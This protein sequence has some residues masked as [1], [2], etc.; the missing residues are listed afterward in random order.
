[1]TWNIH[2]DQVCSKVSKRIFPLYKLNRIL[3]RKC[4]VTIYKT[5]IRPILE[6]GCVIID[7]CSI[8]SS[9]KMENVQRKAA[10]AITGGYACTSHRKLLQEVGLDLLETR[11]KYQKLILL[12]KI[13][14]S[15]TNSYMTS[16]LPAQPEIPYNLRTSNRFPLLKCR[17]L[18][19][20]RSFVPSTTQ[21]WNKVNISLDPQ[22]TETLSLFKRILKRKMFTNSVS[23]Y[24][25]VK[26]K[27]AINQ[28]RIRMGLS[29]LK[30]QRKRYHMIND[31]TCDN[32]GNLHEDEV[33]Y[34]LNC[35]A[36]Y[37]QRNKMLKDVAALLAPNV[38][39]TVLIPENHQES[40][41]I[42][43]ILLCGSKDLPDNQN[44][45]LL[46]HVA[47]YINE[48]NRF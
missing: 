43:K 42:T 4:L 18:K 37:T 32:C 7:G 34:F 14:H 46:N 45:Q 2:I 15:L 16:L 29:G 21:L 19:Y 48:T 33:H 11:R 36:Y 28:T 31:S 30:S 23:Y 24:N 40:L 44:R 3:P 41:N 5:F 35:P 9:K 17:T 27:D 38:H 20:K 26:G 25:H 1:M 6:Y 22:N 39:Y 8:T 13:T 12:F 47:R 10:L